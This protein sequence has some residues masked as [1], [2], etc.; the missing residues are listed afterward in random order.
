MKGKMKPKGKKKATPM[1]MGYNRG[2]KV[3]GK[4]GGY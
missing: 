2:G 4:K 3:K 1:P